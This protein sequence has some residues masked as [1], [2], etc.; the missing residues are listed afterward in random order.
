MGSKRWFWSICI[1]SC[2]SMF[3]GIVSIATSEWMSVIQPGLFQATF[4][5]FQTS[6]T[7][8]NCAGKLSDT[9]CLES[10]CKTFRNWTVSDVCGYVL[11]PTGGR[12]MDCN[13]VKGGVTG[14]GVLFIMGVCFVLLSL[15][16]AAVHSKR[17]DM[18]FGWTSVSSSMLGVLCMLVA[19][20]IFHRVTFV[21]FESFYQ[22]LP[23]SGITTSAGYSFSL[24]AVCFVG[25]CTTM[26]LV[27]LWLFPIHCKWPFGSPSLESTSQQQQQQ[28][29]GQQMVIVPRTGR[30]LPENVANIIEELPTRKLCPQDEECIYAFDPR[31]QKYFLHTCTAQPYCYDMSKPHRMNFLHKGC[32]PPIFIHVDDQHHH[33]EIIDTTD[34]T[35]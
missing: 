16:T 27:G 4:G 5:L 14:T 15:V 33:G 3:L 9:K 12:S 13:R 22:S 24:L 20:I 25:A 19:L 21:E 2:I 30:S 29:N 18:V 31:H 35:F 8:C 7:L 32:P 23:S 11:V 17:F 10:S 28:A 1:V 6:V 26:A 34:P